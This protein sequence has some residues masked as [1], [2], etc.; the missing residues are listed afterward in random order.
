MRPRLLGESRCY[1]LRLAAEAAQSL[2]EYSKRMLG[3]TTYSDRHLV[4]IIEESSCRSF[5][6]K[7][8]NLGARQWN[9]LQAVIQYQLN[10]PDRFI[11]LNI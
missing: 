7:K 10:F 6:R 8:L 9:F 2:S 4:T 3:M 5:S 1:R 11:Q